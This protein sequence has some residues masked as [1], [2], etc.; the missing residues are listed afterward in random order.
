MYVCMHVCADV[1]V[2]AY[3]SKNLRSYREMLRAR[4]D[5]R[6]L[7]L[8]LPATISVP[9]SLSRPHL[10]SMIVLPFS[11][12]IYLDRRNMPRGMLALPDRAP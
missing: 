4:Y 5:R 9:L 8:V 6:L 12:W 11:S 2:Y 7:L 1:Y 3:P 10:L